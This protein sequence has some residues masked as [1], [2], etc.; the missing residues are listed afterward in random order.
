[1][2]RKIRLPLKKIA[3]LVILHYCRCMLTR[4]TYISRLLSAPLRN[5][6]K[7]TKVPNLMSYYRT[8]SK[9]TLKTADI[10]STIKEKISSLNDWGLIE[11]NTKGKTLKIYE[12]NNSIDTQEIQ[13]DN[14]ENPYKYFEMLP[15]VMK[16][17]FLPINFPSSVHPCYYNHHKW[18]EIFYF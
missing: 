9:A 18:L 6:S 13:N 5:Q 11:T 16:T 3:K 10:S 15:P 2:N 4:G 12:L 17:M 1:M 7:Y 8:I 14:V